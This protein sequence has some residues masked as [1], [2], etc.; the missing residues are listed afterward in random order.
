M[1]IHL[2]THGP[3]LMNHKTLPTKCEFLK[4]RTQ[5][6]VSGSVQTLRIH[7]GRS[8]PKIL[9]VMLTTIVCRYTLNI[10]YCPKWCGGNYDRN[11]ETE[12]RWLQHHYSNIVKSTLDLVPWTPD[13]I[14][15]PPYWSTF[16]SLSE[17]K[18]MK[19]DQVY[20][21]TCGPWVLKCIF[22]SMVTVE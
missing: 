10:Q 15:F 7:T 17:S 9:V 5:S 6:G 19:S 18:H 1:V 13:W 22:S 4:I 20:Y 16:I 3:C 21:S 12:E 11:T 2:M 14:F 8:D